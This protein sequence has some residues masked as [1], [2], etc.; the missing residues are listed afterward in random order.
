MKMPQNPGE[1][2]KYLVE[3]AGKARRKKINAQELSE[4]CSISKRTV[5]YLLEQEY[6][7]SADAFVRIVV[8]LRLLPY[9]SMQFMNMCGVTL[10]FYDVYMMY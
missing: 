4:R 3:E 2:L 1:A 10:Q 9:I 6:Q 8:G 7:L 5:Y